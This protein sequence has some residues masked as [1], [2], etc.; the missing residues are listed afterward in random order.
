MVKYL[1]DNKYYDVDSI[2]SNG[3]T[4]LIVAT[5]YGRI[6][7]VEFLLEKNANKRIANFEGKIAYDYALEK[8]LEYLTIILS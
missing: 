4:A 6:E 5:Q 8:K 7:I 3:N 2:D 1:I